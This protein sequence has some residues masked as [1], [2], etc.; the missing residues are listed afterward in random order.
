MVSHR[1]EVWLYRTLE[2]AFSMVL[3]WVEHVGPWHPQSSG[4]NR[5]AHCF[6]GCFV[7]IWVYLTLTLCVLKSQINSVIT[8]VWMSARTEID[9]MCCVLPSGHTFKCNGQELYTGKYKMQW[10]A[11]W[12]TVFWVVHVFG[13]FA[14]VQEITKMGACS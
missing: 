6:L 12:L 10:T 8:D 4:L 13:L 11:V 5:I 2:A 3:V 7:K 9:L 14:L 1:T